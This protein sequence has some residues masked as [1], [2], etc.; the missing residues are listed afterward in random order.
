[1]HTAIPTQPSHRDLHLDRGKAT[2][3]HFS[4]DQYARTLAR[5]LEFGGGS[6]D[7]LSSGPL[8]PMMNVAMLPSSR[9]DLGFCAVCGA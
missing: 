4:S 3:P 7:L 6:N 5:L 8:T 1:M 2:E 9:G